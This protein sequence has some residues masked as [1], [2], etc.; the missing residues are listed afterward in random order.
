[1]IPF[2]ISFLVAAVK[3]LRRKAD[4]DARLTEVGGL[5]QENCQ[6]E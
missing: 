2:L 4:A 6:N 3:F 5:I 1:M